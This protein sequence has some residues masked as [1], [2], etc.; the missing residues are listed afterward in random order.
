MPV[1]LVRSDMLS[2]KTLR[3]IERGGTQSGWLRFILKGVTADHLRKPG[4]E[5]VL[6][7]RDILEH[8]YEARHLIGSQPIP[9]QP[10]PN[11]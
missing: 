10:A 1:M 9:P 6:S 4:T 5:V 3:P 8:T 11:S 2:E 7:F